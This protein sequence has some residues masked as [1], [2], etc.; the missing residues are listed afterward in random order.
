VFFKYLTITPVFEE[1]LAGILP[2]ASGS[3]V[4]AA[5]RIAPTVKFFNLD[6]SELVFTLFS[7]GGLVLTFTI[8][9]C[10]KWR[11]SESHLLGKIWAAG[12]FIWVQLLL[13]GNALPLIDP[14]TLFP[15]RGFSRYVGN[16]HNIQP[17]SWEAVAMAGIYGFVT[18]ALILIL[19]GIITP[20]TE[21]QLRGWRRARKQGATSLPKLSD[22]STSFW[23][24]AFMSLA[25]AAGWFIFARALVESR[26]FPGHTL[27][28]QTL[29]YFAAV[30]LSCGIGFQA[31]LEAKGGRAIGMAAIF[32]GVVPLMAGAVLGSMS[33]RFATA[34]AWIVGLSPASTPFYASST[35]LSLA[36]FPPEVA[37]AIPRAFHFW[38]MVGG[39]VAIWLALRLHAAR[40]AMA[41]R[42]LAAGGENAQSR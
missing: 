32:L 2:E 13:L 14:G 34:S 7:Q 16:F 41:A 38:L 19:G 15:S 29:A 22:S 24:V 42:V 5:Q 35:L 21:H 1:S 28:V 30:M 4:R 18:L 25:G 31:L 12:F 20:T 8:M 40:S 3:I 37:R 39:I 27:P 17:S 6:F 10:R 11:W 26:W 23:A 9:L 36:D 33:D